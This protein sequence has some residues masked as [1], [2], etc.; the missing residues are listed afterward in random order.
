MLHMMQ[1]IIAR[2]RTENEKVKHIRKAGGIPSVVYGNKIK[3]ISL[4]LDAKI[5]SKL[6][7]STGETTLL[8]LH[9][10]GESG[11]RSVLIHD[12]SIDPFKGFFTHVDFY[13]V[14]KD[15]KIKTHILLAFTGESEAV[16]S[17]GGVLVKQIYKIEIEALPNDLPHEVVVDISLLKTFQDVITIGDL[18]LSQSVKV[19]GDPK[20]IIA[21]VIPPRT[22]EELD[23][24]QQEVVMKVDEIKAETEEKKLARDAV[25]ASEKD[26]EI[27]K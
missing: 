27:K 7:K 14:K 21:K 16:K 4:T 20:E 19:F 22:E 24:L 25:K 12:V 15:Q 23:A 11:K 18:K 13:E 6:Y 1:Q 2:V 8:D 5:F 3:N 17:S 9:I 26:T 10:E